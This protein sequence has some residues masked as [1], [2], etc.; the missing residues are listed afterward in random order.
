MRLKNYAGVALSVIMSCQVFA[1]TQNMDKELSGL[2]EK[3]AAQIKETGRK[4]VAILDF[5][6]LQGNSTEL[7]RFVG[8]QFQVTFVERRN[9]VSVMDRAN[10]K[11]IL[12]EHKLTLDGLIEPENA[13]KLGQFA[14]VDAII[15]GK[16]TQLKD[17]VVATANVIATDTAEIIGAGKVTFKADAGIAALSPNPTTQTP[18]EGQDPNQRKKVIAVVKSFG[19]LRIESSLAIVNGKQLLLTMVLTNLNP[20]KSIWVALNTD[21]G[22]NLHGKITDSEGYELESQWNWISGIA[23][24][25]LQHGGFFNATEIKPKDEITATVKFASR[26]GRAILPG[27]CRLQLEI[28]SGRDFNNGFGDATKQNL[29]TEIIVN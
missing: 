12:A 20:R 15:L 22:N 28:L 24:A 23:H 5:T 1:Q 7:S 21:L 6:D 26:D 16:V 17:D 13:K 3:L 27:T 29:V 19:D 25:A 11:K 14:G 8:E 18:T 4:K 9:G 10:L 2:A